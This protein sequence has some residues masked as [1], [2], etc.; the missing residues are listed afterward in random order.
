LGVRRSCPSEGRWRILAT[1]TEQLARLIEVSATAITKAER[2][3]RIHRDRDGWSVLDVVTAW[4]DGV[5]PHLQRNPSPWVDPDVELNV[6]M[7]IRRARYSGARVELQGDGDDTWREIPDPVQRMNHGGTFDVEG[8]DVDWLSVAE[9][10]GLV[11]GAGYW[12]AVPEMTAPIAADLAGVPPAKAQGALT[13]A[14]RVALLWQIAAE[15]EAALG[16]A[17]ATSLRHGRI[18]LT[19]LSSRKGRAA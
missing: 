8:S 3:G 2:E 1:S 9:L 14:V 15:E 11:P 12:L 18:T 4:R 17:D 19:A 10:N 16:P 7:L 6:T 13:V 5:N